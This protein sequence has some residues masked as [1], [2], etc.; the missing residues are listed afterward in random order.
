MGEWMNQNPGTVFLLFFGAVIAAGFIGA[1]RCL[2]VDYGRRKYP[3][4]LN[5]TEY[6]ELNERRMER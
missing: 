6:A 4:R 1:A 2:W 5:E 3:E